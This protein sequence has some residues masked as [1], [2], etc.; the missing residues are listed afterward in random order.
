LDIA[1]C[2]LDI[3][4]GYIETSVGIFTR[5]T[6]SLSISVVL[7]LVLAIIYMYISYVNCVYK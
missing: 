5:F 4:H 6:L 3:K 1:G 7:D 2:V